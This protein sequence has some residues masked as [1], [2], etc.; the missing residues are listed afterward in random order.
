MF[1][2]RNTIAIL[3]ETKPHNIQSLK[4]VDN[5]IYIKLADSND[6]LSMNLQEY[7]SCLH[8]LRKNKAHID[9]TSFL[10]IAAIIG[11][12]VS[13]AISSIDSIDANMVGIENNNS[14]INGQ[15][16]SEY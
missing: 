15:L 12:F 16:V 14:P 3:L 4:Q 10:T 13:V 1:I 7:K 6:E 11:M 5:E 8:Q 2:A 9:R